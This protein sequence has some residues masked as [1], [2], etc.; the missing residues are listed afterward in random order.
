MTAGPQNA[1]SRVR[2][3]AP[4]RDSGL[5]LTVSEGMRA[6]QKNNRVYNAIIYTVAAPAIDSSARQDAPLRGVPYVLKDCWDVA[7]MPATGGSWR[8][9]DRVPA[10]SGALHGAL[11]RTGA[12]LLGKSSLSDLAF[13][14]ECDNHILGPAK[15]PGDLT[16]TSGGSTGGGAVA[17]ATGM[18]AFDWGGDFAGSI[19]MPAGFCGVVGLRLSALAW[20]VGGEHFPFMPEIFRPLLGWGPLA[21]TVGDCRDVIRAVAKDLSAGLAAPEIERDAVTIYAP[22]ARTVAEWPSFVGDVATVLM[23]AGVSFEI[24]Q[25]LPSPNAINRTFDGYLCAHFDAFIR[26]GELPIREA[27]PAVLLGL[28]TNGR[29]DRRVHPTTGLLL[30]LTELGHLTVYRDKSRQTARLEELRGAARKVW[31]DGRLVLAPMCTQLPPRHGKAALTPG[32]ASF[33]KLANLT[34]ATAIAIPLGRFD[35]EGGLPRSLQILGPPGS[36]DAVLDLAERI[37]SVC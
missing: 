34:D 33:C 36:E 16:R 12:V 21:R 8:H 7:G 35:R 5:E 3:A 19:R 1:W 26:T 15:N 14:P 17:V 28:L 31:A 20:P 9:R 18:A 29:F 2:E 4:L 10:R 27:V 24:E 30:A 25:R 11:A 37:E 32:L 22:D 23:Q 13:S 6:I